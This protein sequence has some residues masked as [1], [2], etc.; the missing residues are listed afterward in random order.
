MDNLPKIDKTIDYFQDDST[1]YGTII[2]KINVN[3]KTILIKK[4]DGQLNKNRP[5]GKGI[6]NWYNI[7][8]DDSKTNDTHSAN[9]QINWSVYMSYD[10]LFFNGKPDKDGVFYSIADNKHHQYN[11]E[12]GLWSKNKRVKKE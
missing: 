1:R 10:G 11:I 7:K 12:N 3:N 9:L 6:M 8:N 5:H 2:K 4:Y